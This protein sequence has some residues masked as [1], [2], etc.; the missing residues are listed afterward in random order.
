M[1]AGCTFALRLV[2]SVTLLWPAILAVAQ[3]PSTSL[4]GTISDPSG[5]VVAKAQLSLVN[6]EN[7]FT[8]TRAADDQGEYQ[9]QQLPP[10]TYTVTVQA[11]GFVHESHSVVLMI[12]QPATVNFSLHMEAATVNIN[13][14]GQPVALNSTDATMGDAFEAATIQALPVEGDIPDLL[15]L[16][17]GVLYLG[18]HND[19]SHDSRSGTTAGARSDQNNSTLDG[20]DPTTI[21]FG[22]TLSDRCPAVHARTSVQEFRVTTSGLHGGK[23]DVPRARRST[24]PYQERHQPIS[25]QRLRRRYARPDSSGL[26]DWF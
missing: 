13:V 8:Q 3:S 24:L 18:L 21:R 26:N 25:R 12:N 1:K 20:L 11:P 9:F 17:P 5:A 4:R 22:A 10:G 19:Q 23:P 15:S 2:V 6:G 14:T 7:G 16:Q